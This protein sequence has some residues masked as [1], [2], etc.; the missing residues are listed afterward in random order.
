MFLSFIDEFMFLLMVVLF[1]IVIDHFYN[2]FF[3]PFYLN[4]RE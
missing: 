4:G 1:I 3:R 2:S